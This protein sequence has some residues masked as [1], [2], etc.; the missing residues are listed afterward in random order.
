MDHVEGVLSFIIP[1]EIIFE[2]KKDRQIHILI[3]NFCFLY[4]PRKH[5]YG[6]RSKKEA[7]NAKRIEHSLQKY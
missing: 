7:E 6:H 2:P 3:L 5:H 1:F 4:T